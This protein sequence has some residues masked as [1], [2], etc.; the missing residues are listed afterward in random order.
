MLE[1]AAMPFGLLN[2]ENTTPLIEVWYE[3]IQLKQLYRQ[4]WIQ[5]GID[6]ASCETVAEHTFGNAMLCLMLLPRHP[7]LD[8]LRV[9]MMALVHDV[10]EAY[11]GDITPNDNIPAE[12]KKAREAAAIDKILG[13]L[14]HGEL[15]IEV[16]QESELQ[17]T[18]EAQFVKQ[19]DRLE[20]AMQAS[21]YEHQG[22]IDG[23]EFYD[24]VAEQMKLP[25]LQ[26][27]MVALRS[28]I[29]KKK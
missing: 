7:D 12:V 9:L 25:E 5:R 22:K 18:A 29:G 10:G 17:E 27:E 19:I 23:E 16:W 4:G 13:K 6:P 15:L 2:L 14:P 21:V 1:K 8:A 3:I 26:A 28:I 20:F 11:V 24:K